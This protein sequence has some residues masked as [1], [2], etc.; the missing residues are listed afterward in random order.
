MEASRFAQTFVEEREK[1]V[2]NESVATN[3]DKRASVQRIF[4]KILKRSSILKLAEM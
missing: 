4:L 1:N 2:L 3:H